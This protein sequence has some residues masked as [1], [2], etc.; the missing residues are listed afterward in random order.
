M[1]C[2]LNRYKDQVGDLL[3]P[4][5]MECYLRTIIH[6]LTPPPDL[7]GIIASFLN[8]QEVPLLQNGGTQNH[9][10]W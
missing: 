5:V 2:S 3:L 1:Y 4:A 8:P 9:S 6:W 7:D 10:K